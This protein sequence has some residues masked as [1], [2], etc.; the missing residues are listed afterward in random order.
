M[1]RRVPEKVLQYRNPWKKKSR[2]FP[3]ETLEDSLK[4]LNFHDI[5]SRGR[6]EILKDSP[7]NPATA[8][9]PARSADG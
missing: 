6:A 2:D 4:I 1:S 5:T 8:V 7:K 9:P 3:P